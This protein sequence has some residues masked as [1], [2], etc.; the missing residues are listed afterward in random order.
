MVAVMTPYSCKAVAVC[1]DLYI[2]TN[3]AASNQASPFGVLIS[4][5]GLDNEIFAVLGIAASMCAGCYDLII[6]C[7]QG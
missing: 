4:G 6:S 5:A 3:I 7:D 1:V 2:Y